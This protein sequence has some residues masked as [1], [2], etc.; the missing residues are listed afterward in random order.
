MPAAAQS[1]AQQNYDDIDRA[2][3]NT[4]TAVDNGDY[5]T[6]C[7]QSSF[8]VVLMR[9]SLSDLQDIKPNFDWFKYIKTTSELQEMTCGWAI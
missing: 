4:F 9:S 1:L 2:I 8:A 7:S 5:G 3:K 6:A